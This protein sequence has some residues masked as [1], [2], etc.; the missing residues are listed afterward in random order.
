[1]NQQKDKWANG[2]TERLINGPDNY[3]ILVVVHSV[4]NG[5]YFKD[6]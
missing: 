5:I 1:M 2:Q 6:I 4:S 3:S